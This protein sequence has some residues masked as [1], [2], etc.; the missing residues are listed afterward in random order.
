MYPNSPP[1]L[2]NANPH[3]RHDLRPADALD[4]ENPEG[5]EG[6]D[7]PPPLAGNAN[8]A[9]SDSNSNHRS[10]TARLLDLRRLR[11]APVDER[12]AGLRRLREEQNNTTSG[13]EAEGNVDPDADEPSRRPR[14]ATR[15]RDRFRVKTTPSTSTSGPAS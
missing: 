1:R 7:L 15:L 10:R 4:A 3:S 6:G 5:S 14:L 12:I 8:D 13:G 9:D 2:T 11:H